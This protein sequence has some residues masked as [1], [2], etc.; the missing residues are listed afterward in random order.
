MVKDPIAAF[1]KW[2]LSFDLESLY[3]RLIMMYNISPDTIVDQIEVPRIFVKDRMVPDL[4]GMGMPDKKYVV[5][6]D[7]HS[8]AAN[9][10]RYTKEKRGVIPAEIEKVFLQ[11]KAAKKDEFRA[12]KL[13]TR[14]EAIL[15]ARHEKKAT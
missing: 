3:P 12:D 5:P 6:H 7:G 2:V 15:A 8:Y 4:V 9:G 14:A 10:M 1:Y 13:A 11:R